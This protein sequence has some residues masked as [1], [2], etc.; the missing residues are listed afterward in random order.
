MALDVA[1]RILEGLEIAA[2]GKETCTRAIHEMEVFC[3]LRHAGP[4]Y[5]YGLPLE[6]HLFRQGKVRTQ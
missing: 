1:R 3:S 2:G 4:E 5:T 6:D